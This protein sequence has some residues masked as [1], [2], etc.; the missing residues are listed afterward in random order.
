MTKTSLSFL[1]R[2]KKM[3]IAATIVEKINDIDDEINIA[4]NIAK[5]LRVYGF[6][7]VD[8][9]YSSVEVLDKIKNKSFDL[10][11]IDLL[12]PKIRGNELIDKIS[13]TKKFKKSYIILMSG[14]YTDEIE[15]II[16]F[17]KKYFFLKKPFNSDDIIQILNKI[18]RKLQ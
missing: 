3:N 11:F 12:M 17:S 1:T 13:Q 5:I 8:V 7:N 18:F 16:S 9:N 2:K 14:S 6:K 10:F 15:T 4:D